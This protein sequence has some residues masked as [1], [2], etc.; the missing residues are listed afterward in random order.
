MQEGERI[1]GCVAQLRGGEGTRLPVA[2][3]HGLEV[4]RGEGKAGT[5]EGGGGDPGVIM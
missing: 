3:L 2:A 4:R 1:E 5:G